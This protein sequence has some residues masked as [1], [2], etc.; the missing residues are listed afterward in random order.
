MTINKLFAKIH[1]IFDEKNSES[2][3][4]GRFALAQPILLSQRYALHLKM[5][6]MPTSDSTLQMIVK[7]AFIHLTEFAHIA[8]KQYLCECNPP[9]NAIIISMSIKTIPLQQAIQWIARAAAADGVI[10]PSEIKVLSEFA[11]AYELDAAKIIRLAYGF[12]ND[13]EQ[14]VVAVAPAELKGTRFEEFVVSLCS[15]KSHFKLLA[16]RGD[17]ISGNTYAIDTLMPDLHIRHKIDDR[18]VDYFIEC[19]YRSSWGK[20]DAIDLSPQFVR[21]YNA[22]KDNGIE[23]FIALGVGGTPSNPEEFFRIPG[24]M[25]KLDKQIDRV[26]FVKCRCPKTPAGFQQ[27]IAH[28]FNK[29]IFLKQNE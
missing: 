14:E 27:Y 8:T 4:E 20:D 2:R 28:Y 18:V 17:K 25:V 7:G 22:A 5:Q 19:K 24:R 10:S 6:Y 23:L 29:R 12:S 15:D 21:Y 3:P 11:K 26:R 13:Y 9:C 1:S 16:W